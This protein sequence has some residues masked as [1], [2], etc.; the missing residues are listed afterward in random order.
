MAQNIMRLHEGEEEE[1]GVTQEARRQGWEGGGRNR[2][3][4]EDRRRMRSRWR[5]WERGGEKRKRDAPQGS[6]ETNEKLVY[7]KPVEADPSAWQKSPSA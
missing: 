4:C 6:R 1:S 5:N 2:K 3:R 7:K